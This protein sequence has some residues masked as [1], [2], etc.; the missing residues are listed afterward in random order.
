MKNNANSKLVSR[1][2]RRLT[3]SRLKIATRRSRTA[4]WVTDAEGHY[5][6]DGVS[7]VANVGVIV[8]SDAQK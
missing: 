1:R 2:L 3:L 4:A 5:D 7:Y 6:L 8:A